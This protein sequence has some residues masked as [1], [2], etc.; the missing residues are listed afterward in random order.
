[1]ETPIIEYIIPIGKDCK[2]GKFLKTHNLKK[3]SY[4]FDWLYTETDQ[5]VIIDMLDDNFEKFMDKQYHYKIS[6]KISGHKLYDKNNAMIRHH[7]ILEE[8]SYN[9]YRRCVE[10]FL[11]VQKFEN[12]KLFIIDVE[13]LDHTKKI[14]EYLQIRN[15]NYNI[16]IIQRKHIKYA[17]I[18]NNNIKIGRINKILNLYNFKLIENTNFI[19]NEK[20]NGTDRFDRK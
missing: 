18:K 13:T 8:N 2:I 7:N 19:I 6:D 9:Y 4:P 17:E 1:M 11:E 12:N 20:I 10:R 5:Q 14:L 3:T 16:F 15:K